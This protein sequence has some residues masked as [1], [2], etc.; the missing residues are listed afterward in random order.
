MSDAESAPSSSKDHAAGSAPS[1]S[2]TARH[3]RSDSAAGLVRGS[4]GRQKVQTKPPFARADSVDISTY[5]S[6]KHKHVLSAPVTPAPKDGEKKIDSTER[7]QPSGEDRAP[8]DRWFMGP[9]NMLKHVSDAVFAAREEHHQRHHPDPEKGERSMSEKRLGDDLPGGRLAPPTPSRQSSHGFDTPGWHAPW[10]PFRRQQSDPF[11]H[12]TRGPSEGV[13]NDHPTS[14]P[15][16]FLESVQDFLLYSAFAPL[17]LRVVN[18]AFTASLLGVAARIVVLERSDDLTG[19][20]GI[21]P[22]FALVTGSLTVRA[23]E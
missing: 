5:N 20:I 21:S 10:T 15:M 14:G 8:T 4:V 17:W 22:V 23:C 1:S 19:I 7:R 9:S 12:Y 13:D 16:S 18:L 6:A 3:E 11:D 2:S